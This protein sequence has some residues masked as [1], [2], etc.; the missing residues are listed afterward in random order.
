MPQSFN[1]VG[2]GEV[3]PMTQLAGGGRRSPGPGAAY[4]G[5]FA[6]G[7]ASPGPGRVSPAPGYHAPYGS[8]DFGG[9]ASPG[10]RA[11]QQGRMSP[12]PQAAFGNAY[13]PR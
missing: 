10:P 13:N 9:R 7:R 11:A 2:P 1:P 8:N 3:I 6:S 4:A 5:D 12:G